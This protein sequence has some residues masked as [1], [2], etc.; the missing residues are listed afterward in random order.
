MPIVNCGRFDVN[1]IEDGDGFPI[2]LIHGLAGDHT[3]WLPQIAAFK[4]TYRVIAMDNPGSG[5]SSAV[6]APVTTEELADTM[7]ALM[8]NLGVDKAHVVGRSLG[9]LIGQH[10][11]LRAPE[12]IQSM[13][14]AASTPAVDRIGKR[15]LENMR[16]VLEWRDNWAD[17]ARHSAHVFV[18]PAFYN[19]N[20]EAIARIEALVGNE[21]RSKIS[22][23]NLNHTALT[24]DTS[25]RLGEMTS[26]TLIMAGRQDPVCSMQGTDELSA[27]I[28]NSETVIFEKSSHFF[29]ME[30]AE[31][32]MQT[33]TDW[34]AKQTP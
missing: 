30:E 8:D 24:H 21:A 31:K 5:E 1:Y 3:A 7:I 23:V 27:G 22:Y 32:S 34:F 19:D 14:L 9:G 17:W 18:A 2:V 13:T 28:A 29:L 25:D 33:L 4:D 12:R 6:D 10:M 26:P 15:I 16:E 11:M 20:P